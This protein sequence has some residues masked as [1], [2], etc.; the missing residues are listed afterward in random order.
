MLAIIANPQQLHRGA[1]PKVP[2]EGHRVVALYLTR[3]LTQSDIMMQEPNVFTWYDFHIRLVDVRVLIYHFVFVNT[4]RGIFTALPDY[5]RNLPSQ[6]RVTKGRGI[7]NSRSF[8]YWII[9]ANGLISACSNFGSAVHVLDTTN[10]RIRISAPGRTSV[11]GG[12]VNNRTSSNLISSKREFDIFYPNHHF[13]YLLCASN[14]FFLQRG[15][16]IVYVHLSKSKELNHPS[17]RSH[18]IGTEMAG[19]VQ[20]LRSPLDEKKSARCV[21]IVT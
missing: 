16:D 10:L 20:Q 12:K 11:E 5:S 4:R 14:P 1:L 17:V 3:M 9:T 19:C 2:L 7:M 6:Q 18:S 21:G 15:R 8:S 13:R